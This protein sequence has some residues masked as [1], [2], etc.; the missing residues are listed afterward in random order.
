MEIKPIKKLG[1]NFLNSKRVVKEMIEAADLRPGDFVLE[2]G[3][4]FG[5]LTKEIAKTAKKVVAVEKD[6]RLADFLKQELNRCGNVKIINKDIL[7]ITDYELQTAD[8]KLISS[9]PF[10]IASAVIKKFLEDK[11]PPKQMVLIVQKE[12]AQRITAKPPKMNL[13]SIFVQIYSEPKII[14][15]I[16]KECFSPKPKVTSALIKITPFRDRPGLSQMQ[17]FSKIVKAGF[18]SPRKQLVNNLSKEL[19]KSKPQ[20]AQWLKENNINPNQRAQTLS[21]EDWLNLC[22]KPD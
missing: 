8:Y 6:K 10:Y 22:N 14:S 5:I 15:Y 11:N 19:K 2:I 4:G 1:Q 17:E 18:S 16:P 9:L 13:L 7:Q 21:I 20:I 12:V 3:P